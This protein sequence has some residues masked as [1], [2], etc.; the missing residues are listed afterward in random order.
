MTRHSEIKLFVQLQTKSK[1]ELNINSTIQT[2]SVESE[3][4]FA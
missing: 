4:V 3:E 1:V 2:N